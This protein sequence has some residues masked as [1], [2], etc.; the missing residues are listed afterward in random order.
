VPLDYA[1]L[2]VGTRQCRVLPVSNIN[3]DATG[4]DITTKQLPITDSQLTINRNY[5]RVVR[6]RVF[7]DNISLQPAD[8]VKNPVSLVGVRP[9][10]H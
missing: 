5:A 8:L 7:G 2:I 3:S 10:L 6:N 9:G 1:R 4:F